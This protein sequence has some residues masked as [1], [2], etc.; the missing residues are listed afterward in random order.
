MAKF[1]VGQRVRVV[2]V[3]NFHCLLGCEAR[4]VSWS[5]DGWDGSRWYSGWELSIN[6]PDGISFIAE[7]DDIEP[8]LDRHEPCESKFKESLDKLLSEVSREAV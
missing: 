1:F 7:D 5:E 2:K 4:I 3:M 6:T 8:I